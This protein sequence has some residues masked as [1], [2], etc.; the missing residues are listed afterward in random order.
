MTGLMGCLHSRHD[1]R[2]RDRAEVGEANVLLGTD[3]GSFEL[4]N[5]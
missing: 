2:W 4:N 3:A 1:Q 5:V